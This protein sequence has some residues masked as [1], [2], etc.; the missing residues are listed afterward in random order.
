METTFV[1]E[2]TLRY[3]G[4]KRKNLFQIKDAAGAAAFFRKVLPDNVREHFGAMFLDGAHQVIGYSIVASGTGNCCAISARDLFQPA[5]IVGA[6]NL[7]CSHNHPSGNQEPSSADRQV[8]KSIKEAG[9]LLGI[10]LLDHIIVTESSFYSFCEN[11][12]L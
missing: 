11:S 10:K 7:L 2:V 1:R 4:Q 5:L 12:E 6:L 3:K 8:T 9:E